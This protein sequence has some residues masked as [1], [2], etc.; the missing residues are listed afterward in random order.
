MISPIVTDEITMTETIF[1]PATAAGVGA[2]AMIR[3]SGADADAALTALTRLPLPALRV[4]SVR[5]LH[6][7]GGDVLDEALVIRFAKGASFTGESSVEVQCHGGRAVV[8]AILMALAAVPRLRL[9]EPGEFTRRAL[10]AGR[11]DLAQVEGLADLVAAE[12]DAQRRQALRQMDGVLSRRV[13]AWRKDLIRARA[14][15]EAVIDFVDDDVPLD[16]T[17]EVSDLLTR[18]DAGLTVALDG[19]KAAERVRSGFE[20]ALIG[21]PNA[22]KSTLLNALAGRDVAITSEIAGT[23]RDVIEVSM[24]LNGLA[25]TVLDTAGLRETLDPLESMGIERAMQRARGADLRILLDPDGDADQSLLQLGDLVVRS[26]AD[27]TSAASGFRV[28]ARSGAGMSELLV[29]I[30]TILASR[31][32]DASE[33][34]RMRHHTAVYAAQSLVCSAQRGLAQNGELELIAED[35]RLATSAL[36]S[37]IGRVDAERILDDIFSTFCLGK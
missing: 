25:V 31:V 29:E 20:I 17:P 19:A 36:E 6:D 3:I 22:G 24:D 34:S 9:A 10:E 14:L 33:L 32:L 18:L 2:I 12:T 11:L 5:Q 26:K 13:E 15:I 27:L 30:G 28:S 35:L 7:A 16:V 21:P 1:A 37:V 4:A 8:R 23:T